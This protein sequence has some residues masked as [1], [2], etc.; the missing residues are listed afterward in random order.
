MGS[1]MRQ[2][3]TRFAE[4][5]RSGASG[6]GDATARAP[7]PRFPRGFR[8]R[9]LPDFAPAPQCTLTGII[10]CCT[11]AASASGRFGA[12]PICCPSAEKIA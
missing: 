1:A 6:G 2:T 5:V 3:G 10:S 4:G 9:P 12:K 11:I 7:A 8:P